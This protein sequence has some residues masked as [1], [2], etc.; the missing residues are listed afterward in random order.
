[1]A[2]VAENGWYAVLDGEQSGPMELSVLL[3]AVSEGRANSNTFVWR[4][5]YA[6]WRRA[7]EVEGLS[8]LVAASAADAEKTKASPTPEEVELVRGGFSDE[9][10]NTVAV[11]MAAVVR[12][13]SLGGDPAASPRES[14]DVAPS[15]SM[16]TLF[17]DDPTP[18]ISEGSSGFFDVPE[19][20]AE[21]EKV[22]LYQRRDTSVLFSLDDFGKAGGGAGDG[23]KD[24]VFAERTA[25]SGLIDIRAVARK[26]STTAPGEGDLFD[27]A[28]APAT[29]TAPASRD[30]S[31]RIATRT[32]PLMISR[33]KR[34]LPG[35]AIA[36]GAVAVAGI[37]ALGA[38]LLVPGETQ[39]PQP[40]AVVEPAKEPV[41]PKEVEKAAELEKP[42]AAEP[43]KV[44][45]AVDP[46]ADVGSA[47]DAQGAQSEDAGQ[48]A[49]TESADTAL[50][51]AEVEVPV[52][53][54]PV[55][56]SKKAKKSS[57]KA[58]KAKVKTKPKKENS[59]AP[60]ASKPEPTPPAE[61]SNKANKAT[62]LLD[63]LG[64][65][66][67]G[68]SSASGGSAEASNSDLPAKLGKKD[69]RKVIR[70]YT[71][72]V[73]NCYKKSGVSGG[74]GAVVVTAKLSVAAGGRVSSV[75]VLGPLGG[76]AVG[77]CISSKLKSAK[78]PPF[79]EGPQTV[80]M[81]FR[82]Q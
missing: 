24:N 4:P 3:G 69:I 76:G 44:A 72:A 15:N 30:F 8:D 80:P 5:G 73:V 10:R 26:S 21:S 64:S 6:E 27:T 16:D 34:G 49:D 13:S 67:S 68:G 33:K 17:D 45:E 75:T 25:E 65:G 40:V 41:A 46:L 31:S 28:S 32:E 52:K 39:P 42:K 48:A 54:A 11:D 36:L 59:P 43:E 57:Q 38:T 18:A 47:V 53:K 70:K 20:N 79:Q 77:S 56:K 66:G 50:E 1:M 12:A 58:S 19:S 2:E 23:K 7:G 74:A 29:A 78:F 61:K 55:V 81:T 60:V 9:M 62:A 14:A 71:G 51:V 37:G 35:W 63:S 22:M 82:V